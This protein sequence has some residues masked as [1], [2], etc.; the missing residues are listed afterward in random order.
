MLVQAGGAGI[1]LHPGGGEKHRK[2]GGGGVTMQKG[3]LCEMDEL[4]N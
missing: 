4:R 3:L 1:G 2:G